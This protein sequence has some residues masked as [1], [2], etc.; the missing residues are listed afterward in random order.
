MMNVKIP[1]SSAKETRKKNAKATNGQNKKE[2]VAIGMGRQ[3]DACFTK[4][5]EE[6]V[7]GYRVFEG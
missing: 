7:G 6:P 1:Q 3:N 2:E 4:Q 5:K